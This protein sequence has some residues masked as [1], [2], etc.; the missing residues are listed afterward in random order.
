[1]D[2]EVRDDKTYEFD[3]L[4]EDTKEESKKE[5]DD[6]EVKIR[7]CGGGMKYHWSVLISVYAYVSAAMFVSGVWLWGNEYYVG[8]PLTL[9]GVT[10][11]CLFFI[12]VI[13]Y[14]FCNT[15]SLRDVASKY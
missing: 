15:T 7:K 12:W 6:E 11:S 2:D 9:F 5:C 1:M 14:T 4:E 3:N 10:F 8:I 13:Y